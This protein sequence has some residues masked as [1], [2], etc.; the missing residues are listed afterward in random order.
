MDPELVAFQLEQLQTLRA[1]SRERARRK[2]ILQQAQNSYETC[3]SELEL[4]LRGLASPV[5]GD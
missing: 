4:Y 1:L 3:N 2:D 5:L